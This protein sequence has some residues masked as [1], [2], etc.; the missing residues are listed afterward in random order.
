M[1]EQSDTDNGCIACG[2]TT[3]KQN[4][5]DYAS[6]VKLFYGASKRGVWSIGSDVIL[7]DRPDEG[8]KATIEAKTLDFLA[9]STAAMNIEIPAPKH[10]RD[11]V[12]RDGR[13]F[14]LTERIQGQTLEQAWPS[15][16]ES[17][18]I[19]IA[20]QVVQVRKQLR[21]NFISTTIQTI[22]QGP[23]YPGLLFL[24][25]KPYGP[26]YSEQELWDALA[27]AYDNLPQSIFEN[28]K[29]RFPKSEPFVLTHCD[30]NLGNIMVRDGKVVG[31]LDWE[32]AA[33]LPVWYEYISA[34]F[35]FTEM[36]VEWKKVLR[37]RLG[38]HGDAYDDAKA[39]WKDLISLKQYPDLDQKGKEAF[40]RLNS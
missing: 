38:V 4:R 3:F 5:C 34:S 13:Y 2:W 14:T 30:L 18:K 12:D 36:D 21:S 39:L 29:K 7:K 28:L 8:S 27:L 20:D 6:H 32:Y 37:E 25:M 35:A 15:L 17:Q 26:F 16:S 11:W 1:T 22:D 40:E 23:C 10:I 9:K 33:Y 31:I 24:D 19:S